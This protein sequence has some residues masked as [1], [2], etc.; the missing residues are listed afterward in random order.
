MKTFF[1][2]VLLKNSLMGCSASL[3][4]YD[5]KNGGRVVKA[6]IFFFSTHCNFSTHSRTTSYQSHLINP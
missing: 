3:P 2:R 5:A 6:Y 1:S 4:K